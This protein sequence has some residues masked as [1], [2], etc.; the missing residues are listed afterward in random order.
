LSTWDTVAADPSRDHR[1]YALDL[2]GHGESE[3]TAE[4]SFELMRDDVCAF[5]NKLDLTDVTLVG[6]S[7]GGVVAYLSANKLSD[8][9]SYLV[10]EETPPPFPMGF[11]VPEDSP[12]RTPIVKQLNDP[13]PQ[14]WQH[15]A[16]IKAKTLIIGGG[17][18]SFLP[19]HLIAQMA[20]RFPDG[21][22]VTILVG[23]AVHAQ[24]PAEFVNALRG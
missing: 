12:V 4:Y 18:K 17:E 20:Q 6:H 3:H 5:A 19:Q 16:D 1:V 13:D 15:I 8:R 10:L 14:W 9:I 24:V 2:R 21:R 23:H 22:L 11:P 7:M